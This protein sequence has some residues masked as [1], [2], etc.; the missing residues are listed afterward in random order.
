MK[1]LAIMGDLHIDSNQFGQAE[2]QTLIQT[3]KEKE[4]V[5]LHLAG[6][7]SNHHEQASLP[8]L[9][10]LQT[11]QPGQKQPPLPKLQKREVQRRTPRVHDL[12]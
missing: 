8:F 3:L 12:V 1:K 11:L 9:E 6:D 5:H 7:I 2:I 4:V 10:P